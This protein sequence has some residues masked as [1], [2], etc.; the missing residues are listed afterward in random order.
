MSQQTVSDQR[1][2]SRD[3]IEK[4]GG[5]CKE[6]LEAMV[7]ETESSPTP[8]QKQSQK[9]ERDYSDKLEGHREPKS[10]KLNRSKSG[11]QL[12]DYVH[13]NLTDLLPDLEGFNYDNVTVH[14]EITSISLKGTKY[15]DH[16]SCKN[17]EH[18]L[19]VYEEYI[20]VICVQNGE[21]IISNKYQPLSIKQNIYRQDEGHAANYHHFSKNRVVVTSPNGSNYMWC[22]LK[23]LWL[24]HDVN[25]LKADIGLTLEREY[26]LQ[27]QLKLQEIYEERKKSQE[28]F[29]KLKIPDLLKNHVELALS[30]IIEWHSP[31]IME[32]LKE[33]EDDKQT[34]RDF[35]AI[36]KDY[37]AFVSEINKIITS[38]DPTV[39]LTTKST[40]AI[41][42]KV[43][44]K[45]TNRSF[46][47]DLNRNSPNELPIKNGKI[48]DLTN[49][50]VRCRNIDDLFSF[51][52]PVEYLGPQSDLE[53]ITTFFE[54]IVGHE[55]NEGEE[56]EE[57]LQKNQK[58]KILRDEAVRM[59]QICLGYCMT[60]DMSD[61]SFF[62]HQGDGSNG[63][64]TTFSFLQKVLTSE[65]GLDS[66]FATTDKSTVLR[67]LEMG[68]GSATPHLS[69]LKIARA[70]IT[71]E[72]N[73]TEQLDEDF[74][75]RWTSNTDD[76]SCRD[77]YKEA[78][79]FRP[80]GK[81]CIQINKLPQSNGEPALADRTKII[82]YP[83]RFVTNPQRPHER[84]IKPVVIQTI[85]DDHMDSFFTFCVLGAIQ[86]YKDKDNSKRIE[87]CKDS[88][89]LTER[90]ITNNDNVSK[91][92][93]EACVICSLKKNDKHVC[94]AGCKV[95]ISPT[96]II[97]GYRKWCKEMGENCSKSNDLK[98]RL[99]QL[100]FNNKKVKIEKSS[101]NR[102]LGIDLNG[103]Y[104]VEK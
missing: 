3:S 22:D 58:S 42:S 4:T 20:Q 51:E 34:I 9:R 25:V 31:K 70:V 102:W 78:T 81:L 40:N 26:N 87:L 66:F 29:N 37:V 21:Q 5:E 18:I 92:V 95:Q 54:S 88:A 53:K 13:D 72:I 80:V 14:D 84:L 89:E 100:G 47:L 85:M 38:F 35:R 83:R 91:F 44:P 90:Y 19:N 46:L 65:D 62:M 68:K 33:I 36:G 74:V 10:C 76:F 45:L 99:E 71:S 49:G 60:G 75:K 27:I 73:E 7:F 11:V 93:E 56:S 28:K 55:D 2:T 52:C 23:K 98:D 17:T 59:H 82:S 63:K 8:D 101:L 104:K 103:D 48:I 41:F 64:G 69:G 50:E 79:S 77:L 30:E 24:Q 57:L 1:S 67:R 61:R 96:D 39:A 94:D 16:K 97:A 12:K 6:K 86:F 43:V 32:C 15:C